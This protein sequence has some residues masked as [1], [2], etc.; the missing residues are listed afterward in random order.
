MRHR[1]T[2]TL[3]L[4]GLALAALALVPGQELE[5]QQGRGFL[6]GR[7]KVT[8]SLNMGY[9]LARA[10]S[11]VY[12]DYLFKDL[13]LGKSDFNAPV[14]AGNLAVHLNER[15]DLAL[16]VGYSRTESWSEYQ[17][18]V[19]SEELPIEQNTR[20]TRVPITATFRYFFLDR[21]REVSRFAWIPAAWSPYVGVGAGRM[22]Y[23]LSHIGDFIDFSGPDPNAL[24]IFSDRLVSDG[25]AWTGHVVGGA[26]V[27]LTP[28]LV[29][30]GEGRYVWAKADLDRNSFQG[31]QPIDLSGFQASVGLGVRF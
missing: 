17:D 3:G 11:D 22:Y 8:L 19:D 25:T 23:K 12:S 4:L 30:T 20:L 1:I 15:L 16:E 14:L 9:E 26:Q 31:F 24:P 28:R 27:S 2:L 10:G 6:F 5:A 13:T 21:G 18:F 7:P 29:L